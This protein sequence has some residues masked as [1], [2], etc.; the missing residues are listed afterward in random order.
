MI[1]KDDQN[2]RPTPRL[3]RL[4]RPGP[5]VSRGRL[6]RRA[7]QGWRL[8]RQT[9]TQVW[10]DRV[11]GLSAEAGFWA[12]LSLTPLLLILVAGIGYLTPLFG[13]DVV[14]EVETRILTAAEQVLAP[15]ATRLRHGRAL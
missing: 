4:L 3:G 8:A 9:V 15:S 11:L 14:A 13:T 1:R 12:L 2:G 7:R 10:K 5:V 6:T